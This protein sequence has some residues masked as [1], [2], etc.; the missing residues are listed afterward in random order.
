MPVARWDVFFLIGSLGSPSSAGEFV[1]VTIITKFHD[2]VDAN[3][4]IAIIVIVRL[5]NSAKR[6]DRYFIIIAE[7]ETKSFNFTSI[8]IATENES[9]S[10]RFAAAVY[11][12]ASLVYY[13]VFS[14]WSF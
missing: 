9:L 4:T 14:V 13:K 7:I 5:P 11:F 8:K 12:I 1:S 3:T 2:V 6:V 10:I